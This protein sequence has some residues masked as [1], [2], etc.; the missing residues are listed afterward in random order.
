MF[1]N[2]L[3]RNKVISNVSLKVAGMGL[4]FL[5][6]IVLARS[7]SIKVFSDYQLLLQTNNLFVLFA[8]YSIPEAIVTSYKRSTIDYSTYLL[9]LLWPL[10]SLIVFFIF[11]EI[12][13]SQALL[14]LS[15]LFHVYIRF[16]SS[17]II[18]SGWAWFA[19]L[20]D[21]VLYYLI[22]LGLLLLFDQNITIYLVNIC[23]IILF[24]R[25]LILAAALY[26]SKPKSIL[27]KKE[28]N[29][30]RQLIVRF[31]SKDTYNF[32]TKSFIVLL[33]IIPIMWLDFYGNAGS[34]ALFGVAFTVSNAVAFLVPAYSNARLSVISEYLLRN[35][36]SH[37]KHEVYK[38]SIYL[39]SFGILALVIFILFGKTAL[40]F[41][42]QEYVEAYYITSLLLLGQVFN[43]FGG[44]TGSIFYLSGK[45]DVSAFL[46]VALLLVYLILFWFEGNTEPI[47]YALNYTIILALNTILKFL[48]ILR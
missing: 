36:R 9:S 30:I 21:N 32:I 42:G 35:E 47:F 39:G 46:S 40:T 2:F 24:S 27:I 37:V 5:F 20:L 23:S 44:I 45:E 34:I 22:A 11:V 1:T 43:L 6:S 3:N 7:L 18:K 16:L 12:S 26:A 29:F 25:F 10:T 8:M 41:W 14:L 4:G 17:I 28:N 19:T 33:P 13:L 31:V 48:L 38:G 15:G